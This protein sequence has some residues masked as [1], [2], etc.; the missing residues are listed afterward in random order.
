MST[1]FRLDDL[2]ALAKK[3]KKIGNPECPFVI[4]IA[5]D[6]GKAAASGALQVVSGGALQSAIVAS[7]W[8]LLEVSVIHGGANELNRLE[9]SCHVCLHCGIRRIHRTR[10]RNLVR[11]SRDV[12]DSSIQLL[13]ASRVEAVWESETLRAARMSHDKVD[14]V[15]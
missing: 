3:K 4:Q 1:V 8:M 6:S 7:C 9:L 15:C 11:G 5:R 2:V 14:Y 10:T 12:R 13:R